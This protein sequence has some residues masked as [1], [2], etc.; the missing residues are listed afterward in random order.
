M[1]NNVNNN[2][3]NNV[4]VENVIPN[5]SD[6]NPVVPTPINAQSIQPTVS[7][8]TNIVTG[9]TVSNT[10]SASLQTGTTQPVVTETPTVGTE[11]PTASV[12][13]PVG[14]VATPSINTTQTVTPSATVKPSVSN[15]GNN[16]EVAQKAYYKKIYIM[17]GIIV[18]SVLLIAG[19]LLY[20]LLNGT[21]ENRNRLTC[22]KT[23]Q[24][25]GYQEHI[26]RYYTFDGGLMKRVYFTHTF[27]YDNLTDDMYDQKF[28][29]VIT[30]DNHPISSYGLGTNISRDG[31]VVTVTA[32]DDNYLGEFDK[33]I[34]KRNKDEGYSCE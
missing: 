32:F 29:N 33:D 8:A 6:T 5:A 25:D 19:I 13:Q 30:N 3:E 22:T 26:K 17:M 24:G 2:T 23:I 20:F 4:N 10:A 9:E 34:L 18:G 12:T 1:D 7:S 14:T 27:T 31:N 11:V 15:S 16:D 21:I 28:G